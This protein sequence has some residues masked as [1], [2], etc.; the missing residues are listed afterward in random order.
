M[1]NS[2]K[3]CTKIANNLI[4]TKIKTLPNSGFKLYQNKKPTV[5]IQWA[6]QRRNL[7]SRET[8]N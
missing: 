2:Y 7:I 1:K 6:E 5:K 8:I 3:I 4:Q